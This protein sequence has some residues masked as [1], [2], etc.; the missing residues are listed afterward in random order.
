MKLSVEQPRFDFCV[1]E[2]AD[3]ITIADA[4]W[5]PERTSLQDR[6]EAAHQGKLVLLALP[7]DGGIGGRIVLGELNPEESNGWVAKAT[8]HVEFESGQL[9]FDAG[10]FFGN[11]AAS[12]ATAAPDYLVVEIPKGSFRV[13][14]YVYLP[15]N[16]ATELL[17]RR[18]L[19]YLDWFRNSHPDSAVPFWLVDLAE[20]RDNDFEDERLDALPEDDIDI[21]CDEDFVEILFQLAPVADT[22][23]QS[24]LKKSGQPKWEIRIPQSFPSPM[25]TSATRGRQGAYSQAKQLAQAFRIEDFK[26]CSEIFVD[27]M[28]TDVREFL[29][30]QHAAIS[31]KMPIPNR[32]RRDQSERTQA[33]WDSRYDH[34]LA[35]VYPPALR[36]N[37]FVGNE[38]ATLV[39]LSDR[40]QDVYI[41]FALAFVK[42]KNGLEAAGLELGRKF[43]KQRTRRRRRK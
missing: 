35:L 40:F 30:E 25:L 20:E 34:P 16:F 33:D 39:D 37:K 24:E 28:R 1:G 14:A 9:V 42:T 36:R 22:D 11:E 6:S 26:K 31:V 7:E 41:S 23:H 43:P 19:S 13:S 17:K 21:E 3:Y 12:D 10:G 15:S 5:Q 18:K 8:R 27:A 32:L 2:D 4:K 38:V 29:A